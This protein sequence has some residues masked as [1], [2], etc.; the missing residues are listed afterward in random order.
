MYGDKGF[1]AFRVLPSS[2]IELDGYQLETFGELNE[3]GV[4]QARELH[5]NGKTPLNE[6]LPYDTTSSLN[7]RISKDEI[8]DWNKAVNLD[9]DEKTNAKRLDF[10]KEKVTKVKAMDF[11][12][13]AIQL[14]NQ[15]ENAKR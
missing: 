4:M 1:K 5:V 12:S 7:S 14:P 15:G 6:W 10:P 13:W 8:R 3:L 11:R 2:T 9:W